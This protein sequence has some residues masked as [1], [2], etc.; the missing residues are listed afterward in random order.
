M[1]SLRTL[2]PAICA[3]VGIASAASAQPP[4]APDQP[5]PAGTGELVQ[6]VMNRMILVHAILDQF[7]GRTD[8]RTPDFRWSGEGWIGTD[9][10]KFWVKTEGFR[11]NNGTVDDG[12]HEFL[13]DRSISTFFSMFRPGCAAILIPE[14]RATGPRSASRA[15]RHSFLTS[16][17]RVM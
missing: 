7:E 15:S 2:I 9:Y 1:T 10:D 4:V 12:Q 16:R 11:R 6:P 8:G 17:A 14:E 3:F 13:Y 5:L